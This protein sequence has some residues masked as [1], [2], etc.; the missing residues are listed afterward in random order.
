MRRTRNIFCAVLLFV[1]S[2][3]ML[4][5]AQA[6]AG[7]NRPAGVPEEYVI[8]PFGYFH[9]SCVLQIAKGETL[10]ADGRVLQ[11]ADGTLED[12]PACEY[13]HYV[14]SGEIAG[15]GATKVESPTIDGW[16][17]YASQT[18]GT[19]FYEL[20]SNEWIVPPAP[21]SNNGQT[22]FF[23]QGLEDTNDVVSILQP[24]LQY[25][26][27]AAGGGDNWAIAAWNCCPSG[28]ADYSSLVSVKPSDEV[29]GSISSTCRLG[30]EHCSTWD[31]VIEDITTAKGTSLVNSPSEGQTFNWAFGGVLEA[32]NVTQCSD[33]PSNGSLLFP[34]INLFDYNG[35][36]VAQNWKG[37]VLGGSPSCSYAVSAP[38]GS[39]TVRV[40]Y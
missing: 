23:F 30:T 39:D 18:I 3:G 2:F 29:S 1:A 11:H 14:A 31:I 7:K 22:L 12:L 35:N 38:T 21:T 24:V 13:P 26:K 4:L 34:S 27:S 19:E 25:G 37:T 20:F 15:A 36:L 32:Y 28:T 9:P 16:V 6:P 17:E 8:T 10:L 5:R 40:Y 33:Y